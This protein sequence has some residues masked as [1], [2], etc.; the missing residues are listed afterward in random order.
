[1]RFGLLAAISAPAFGS[2]VLWSHELSR[3]MGGAPDEIGGSPDEIGAVPSVRETVLPAIALHASAHHG[4]ISPQTV[5][6]AIA[7][8][9]WPMLAM[10][11]DLRLRWG[12]LRRCYGRFH[13]VRWL[14]PLWLLCDHIRDDHISAGSSPFGYCVQRSCTLTHGRSSVGN[15]AVLSTCMQLYLGAWAALTTA[16]AGRGV[17]GGEGGGEGGGGGEADG[18]FLGD[19]IDLYVAPRAPLE[20][21]SVAIEG[22]LGRISVRISVALAHVLGIS[23]AEIRSRRY[24]LGTEI[25]LALL[26]SGGGALPAIA[27]DLWLLRRWLFAPAEPAPSAELV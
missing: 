16:F 11:A 2:S 26:L 19:L 5:L 25:S 14:V 21:S 20:T 7:L 24:D 18:G 8:L 12:E 1:M 3:R 22:A 6:P 13:R 15:G 4:A 17:G 10:L 27:L 23:E 9:L